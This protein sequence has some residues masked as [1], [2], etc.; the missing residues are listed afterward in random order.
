MKN[1]ILLILTITLLSCERH[2]RQL[3]ELQIR[4]DSLQNAV[5]NTYK[6]GFG[7][8]MSAIQAHHAKLWYAGRNDNWKL[9]DFEIHELMELTEDIAH[10]QTER[11]E[12]KLIG[13]I[14]PAMDSVSS[15]VSR[16]DP[17]QFE[18]SFAGLTHACNNCHRET[19]FEFNIVR[20]PESPAFPNQDFRPLP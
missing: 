11:P 2:N 15:A 19:G 8:F 3:Q 6:P 1:G 20:I 9:A 13:M 4:T 7:E 18:K 14:A 16:R 5:D 17:G 10:Y 12:S